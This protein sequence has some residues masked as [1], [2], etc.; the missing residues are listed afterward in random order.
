M[1]KIIWKYLDHISQHH[2]LQS[3]KWLYER[4]DIDVECNIKLEEKYLKLWYETKSSFWWYTYFE[5]IEDPNQFC[6]YIVEFIK[7]HQKKENYFVVEFSIEN[8]NLLQFITN[9]IVQT[10]LNKSKRKL[11]KIYFCTHDGNDSFNTSISFNLLGNFEHIQSITLA[12]IGSKSQF[13]DEVLKYLGSLQHLK[14]LSFDVN[15]YHDSNITDEGLSFI[16]NVETMDFLNLHMNCNITDKG[17]G[18]LQGKK[19]KKFTLFGNFNITDN[20]IINAFQKGK[21]QSLDISDCVY[22]TEN[23]FI[24]LG[25]SLEEL[26]FTLSDNNTSI[27][28]DHLLKYLRNIKILFLQLENFSYFCITQDGICS[29]SHSIENLTLNGNHTLTKRDF[30]ILT[31]NQQLKKIHF[32]DIS[33]KF[34]K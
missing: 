33:I 25:Y 7:S 13:N 20:G 12:E 29:I 4:K 6:G 26:Y 32:D 28:T 19:I 31:T 17:L 2:Y 10:L 27:I 3:W 30:Q 15:H 11:K 14:Q 8:E 23:A 1:Q 9:E 34:F 21:I 24:P 22:I 5:L 18:Y 16:K